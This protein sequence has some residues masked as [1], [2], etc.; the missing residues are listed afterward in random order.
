[1]V[2]KKIP[3]LVLGSTCQECINVPQPEKAPF[4]NLPLPPGN[5]LLCTAV[6]VPNDMNRCLNLHSSCG[7]FADTIFSTSITI[8]STSSS[9]NDY[10]MCFS[11]ITAEMNGTRIHFFYS[12][13]T[14]CPSGNVISRV[15]LDSYE[16]VVQGTFK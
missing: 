8:C 3:R 1:M 11:N 2:T 9:S 14:T 4:F 10:Q 5:D 6:H 13:S 16:I 15:Y 7:G 12:T